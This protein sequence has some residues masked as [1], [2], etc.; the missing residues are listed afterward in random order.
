MEPYSQEAS[1]ELLRR[2][3]SQEACNEEG[4]DKGT[5]WEE[6]EYTCKEGNKAEGRKP[7][8]GGHRGRLHS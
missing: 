6:G 5:C 1:W 4:S 8:W 7:L 2:D 3:R